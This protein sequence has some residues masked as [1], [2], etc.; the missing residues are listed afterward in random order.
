MIAS[1]V[2]LFASDEPKFFALPLVAGNLLILL[3]EWRARRR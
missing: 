3:D 2:A 1:V